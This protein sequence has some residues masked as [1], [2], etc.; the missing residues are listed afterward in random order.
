MDREEQIK[1]R[2]HAIW[3]EEGRPDQRSSDHWERAEREIDSQ[4]AQQGGNEE[5][6]AALASTAQADALVPDEEG[7][8]TASNEALLQEGNEGSAQLHEDVTGSP[9]PTPLG[10]QEVSRH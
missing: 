5:T 1:A 3:E 10:K 8:A 6:G 4:A 2:A 9:Q 7:G